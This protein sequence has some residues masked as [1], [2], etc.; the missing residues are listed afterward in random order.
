MSRFKQI[1]YFVVGLVGTMVMA[2]C[3]EN[4][5]IGN[6]LVATDNSV[7]VDKDF[8][9]TGKTLPMDSIQ[10]RTTMQ[11]LGMIE[12]KGYGDFAS[13]F[14]TQYMP[15]AELDSLIRTPENIDSIKMLLL[16]AEGA[17]VG[18]SLIP[19]GLEVYRLNKTLTAPIYSNFKVEDY[20]SPSDRVG[21]AIYSLNTI[22]LNDSLRDLGY[23]EIYVNLPRSIATELFDIYKSNPSVYLSPTAFGQ[24]FKGFYVRNSYG[25]GRVT[26]IGAN[27]LVMYYHYTIKNSLGNDSIVRRSGNF[28][29]VT[30]EIITN[31]NIDYTISQELLDRA[32]A[33]ENLLVAPAG[34]EVELNFPLKDVI[35]HYKAQSGR[36]SVVNNLSLEIPASKIANTYNINAPENVLLILK[37]KKKDFFRN[38]EVPDNR[39]SFV[40]SYNTSTGSYIFSSMRQYLLDMLDKEDLNLDDFTFVITPVTINNLDNYNSYYGTSSSVISSVVPYVEQPSMARLNLDKSTVTLTFTNQVLK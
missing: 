21:S 38:S 33:G 5:T 4:D 12:A 16:V 17:V 36:L 2:S 19:M 7:I 31:N 23:R 18:D 10:S 3:D 32:S 6:S 35:A 13:D 29:A 37:S 11:L 14:V 27:T 25:S 28:Y 22:E 9:L 40:A 8:T 39:T 1:I 26:K 20:Y 15:A 34:L 30:P 24:Q